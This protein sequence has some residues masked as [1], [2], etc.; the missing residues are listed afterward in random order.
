MTF[1]DH[2]SNPDGLKET[3]IRVIESAVA[4]LPSDADEPKEREQ[5]VLRRS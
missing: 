1:V 2:V 5:H 4:Q 3:T